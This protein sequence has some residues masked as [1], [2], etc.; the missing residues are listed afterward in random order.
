MTPRRGGAGDLFDGRPLG[1]DYVACGSG[2]VLD[3]LAQYSDRQGVVPVFLGPA[4]MAGN[5]LSLGVSDR[6]QPQAFELNTPEDRSRIL[7]EAERFDRAE[8]D[9]RLQDFLKDLFPEEDGYNDPDA[10]PEYWDAI[11][12]K[13]MPMLGHMTDRDSEPT[14]I[15]LFPCDAP[16]Q[17]PALLRKLPYS[18]SRFGRRPSVYPPE[19][20]ETDVAILKDWE[21]RHDARIVGM[22]PDSLIL[23][24]DRPPKTRAEALAIARD[25]CAYG[26]D[27]ENRCLQGRAQV[28]LER[29]Y[30]VL[31]WG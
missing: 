15:G 16:W 13:N 5:G 14:I 23:H 29:D 8:W 6:A 2:Q 31:W 21:R 12:D 25:H 19:G 7:A 20:P 26:D 28:L 30:W 9:A 22:L 27:E 17:F 4:S 1:I 18:A 3:V 11:P 24:V 10:D